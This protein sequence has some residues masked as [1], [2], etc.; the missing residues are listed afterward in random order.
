[1]RIP[2]VEEVSLFVRAVAVRI[3]AMVWQAYRTS[4][5]GFAFALGL[6]EEGRTSRE[7]DGTG[8]EARPGRAMGRTGQHGMVCEGRYVEAR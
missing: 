8:K 3:V 5:T 2:S 6:R 7:E 1:M 4:I